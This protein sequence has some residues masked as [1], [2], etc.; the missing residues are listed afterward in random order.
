MT[1]SQDESLEDQTAV[2]RNKQNFIYQK[3]EPLTAHKP[4]Q[5]KLRPSQT[6]TQNLQ[7]T[8]NHTADPGTNTGISQN[9]AETIATNDASGQPVSP[10]D[11]TNYNSSTY[12]AVRQDS[13]VIAQSEPAG[14]KPFK[15][16]KFKSGHRVNVSRLWFII[17]T[18]NSHQFNP[19]K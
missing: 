9:D 7:R 19:C 11:A 14:R 16:R 5:R 1:G 13:E 6:A 3:K 8:F 2:H 10:R 12:G 4:M 18:P 15:V 17:V